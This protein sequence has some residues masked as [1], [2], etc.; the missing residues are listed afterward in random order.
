MNNALERAKK[1]KSNLRL[2]CHSSWTNHSRRM[3][4]QTMSMRL[5]TMMLSFVDPS[6]LG[7]QICLTDITN[8]LRQ[9]RSSNRGMTI[10]RIPS[11]YTTTL[12]HTVSS[13]ECLMLRWELGMASKVKFQSGEPS[14][15]VAR[16]IL[17]EKYARDS[18]EHSVLVSSLR[19][20]SR[21]AKTMRPAT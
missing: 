21:N 4:T 11:Y 19:R 10:R 5:A 12:R 15:M 1:F 6:M 20:Q 18:S 13:A 8:S 3:L 9:M 14:L 17:S 16:R 7:T 2:R